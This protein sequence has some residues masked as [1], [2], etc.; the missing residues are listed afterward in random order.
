MSAFMIFI[1]LF[2]VG[3]MTAIASPG[4]YN[5]EYSVA[6]RPP[7]K[8]KPTPAPGDNDWFH[9]G[10]E[11]DTYSED[12]ARDWPGDIGPKP[13]PGPKPKAWGDQPMPALAPPDKEF[14]NTLVENSDSESS[15]KDL[16]D[17]N[18]V[19]EPNQEI[20]ADAESSVK[21]L[22]PNMWEQNQTT[23]KS[24]QPKAQKVQWLP[25]Y[26][27]PYVRYSNFCSAGCTTWTG[28]AGAPCQCVFFNWFGGAYTVWGFYL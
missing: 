12:L 20:F 4:S 5:L 14:N 2:I 16:I 3:P 27:N 9:P 28:L 25:P 7:N 18:M 22:G 21:D 10:E 19:I 26:W 15:T 11:I 1:T 8:P 23:L 24:N 13:K 17:P 6:P